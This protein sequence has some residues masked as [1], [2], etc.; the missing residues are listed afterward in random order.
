M[1]KIL[2]TCT[3]MALA[4]SCTMNDAALVDVV[5]LGAMQKSITVSR[6]HGSCEA[7]VRA[8]CD[9]TAGIISGSEWLQLFGTDH[10]SLSG[11]TMLE[12]DYTTNNSFRRMAVVVLSA[13][14][15][16]DTLRICQEGAIPESIVLDIHEAD[17]SPEGQTFRIP[18]RTNLPPETLYATAGEGI[19][20]LAISGH[21]LV[22][23]VPANTGLTRKK[24][25]AGIHHA[26]GWGEDISDKI[27]I[28]QLKPIN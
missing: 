17:A 1:K 7:D 27:I 19:S 25:S 28:T 20:G 15:R 14:G 8:N 23:T 22:F 5:S 13:P 16:T 18:F 12:M 4:L 21:T 9:F 26:G 11:N 6:T 10:L 2:L 24:Y 3:L